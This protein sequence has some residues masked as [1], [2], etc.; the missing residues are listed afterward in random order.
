MPSAV[1]R[2][3]GTVRRKPNDAPEAHSRMLFGP[4]RDRAHDREPDERGD[5]FH[6]RTVDGVAGAVLYDPARHGVPERADG[7]RLEATDPRR[8]RGAARPLHGPRVSASHPRR[9]DASSSSTTV[10]SA[11]TLAGTTGWPSRRW[12]RCCRRTWPMTVARRG[13]AATGSGSSTSSRTCSARRSIG[14]SVDRPDVRCDRSAR[15]GRRPARR[16]RLR[17]RRARRGD[18]TRI[19]RRADPR[20]VRD[21]WDVRPP[22]R[23]HPM[24]PK[25]SGRSSMRACST[26]SR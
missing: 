7:P 6:D 21:R 22:I 8:P 3:C 12:S 1:P 16:P 2:T 18:T 13:P 14:R 15:R 24:P 17:R 25:R 26:R 23:P 9:L 20:V 11:T 4:G 5:L 19:R 10:S